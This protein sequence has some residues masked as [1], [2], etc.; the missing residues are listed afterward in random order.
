MLTDFDFARSLSLA[1]ACLAALEERPFDPLDRAEASAIGARVDQMAFV[2]FEIDAAAAKGAKTRLEEAALILETGGRWEEALSGWHNLAMW[3]RDPAAV[4]AAALDD[5]V[6]RATRGGWIGRAGQALVAKASLTLAG[7]AA[8]GDI[9]PLLARARQAFEAAGDTES[10]IDVERVRIML[11]LR[12]GTAGPAD[13]ERLAGDYEAADRPR[14]TITVLL[15]LSTLAHQSGDLAAATRLRGRIIRLAEATGLRLAELNGELA[16]VD[17]LLRGR[18]LSDAIDI[19]L[20]GMARPAP[21]FIQVQFRQMLAT[22]YAFAGDE[23]K[24]LDARRGALAE[25]T[26]MHAWELAS[27][28]ATLLANQR[29]GERTQAAWT[30]SRG[31]AR[32]WLDDD[33]TRGNI[34]GAL[35]NLRVAV[36][37]CWQEW[38]FTT[39]RPRPVERLAEADALLDRGDALAGALA[40]QARARELGGLAQQRGQTLQARG[41]PGEP[42]GGI[43]T[44]IQHYEAGGLAM[45]AANSRYL[46]GVIAL[47]A[48]AD[49]W[50]AGDRAA[51]LAS[52]GQAERRLNEALEYYDGAAMR[53]EAADTRF[54]L[55][56]HYANTAP[57]TSPPLPDQMRDGALTHLERAFADLDSARRQYASGKLSDAQVGKLTFAE[58]SS[59]IVALALEILLPQ[60]P[61]WRQAWDWT[62]RGKSRALSDL[63]GLY[64][65]PPRRIVEALQADPADA[66][67]LARQRDL[68]ARLAVAPPEAR[69]GLRAALDEAA[70]EVAALPRWRAYRQFTGGAPLAFDELAAVLSADEAGAPAGVCIDWVAVGERLYLIAARPGE[71]PRVAPI[72]LSLAHVGAFVRDHLDEAHFRQTLRDFPEV[73]EDMTPLVEPLAGLTRPEELLVLCPTGPLHAVPLHALAVDGAALIA[74]NP[75][76]YTH[77]LGVTG[78]AV[79]RRGDHQATRPMAVFG[80]PSQDRAA[81]AGVAEQLHERFAAPLFIGGQVTCEALF[82]ALETA[83]RVHFQGHAAYE[84]GSPLESGLEVVGAA[85]PDRVRV[86]DIL[87]SVR[88]VA[89]LVSL[90]ACES[91]ANAVRAGDD[92]LGVAPALLVAGAGGVLGALWRVDET[93]CAAFTERLYAGLLDPAKPLAT[94]DAL[95]SAVRA[96]MADPDTDTP[97]HWGAYVL[98]GDWR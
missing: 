1:K 91:A 68:V 18:R 33:V 13:L 10:Q 50:R 48:T 62:Q 80:D 5:V 54:M 72:A 30:E 46:L 52:F 90:G 71:P 96:L 19:C 79:S 77:S 92:P 37:A 94:T 6:E 24:C 14:D 16:L 61:R 81:A 56:R 95:R 29:L 57:M 93:A 2:Y 70:A 87:G 15:D 75:V 17:I 21:R 44:A 53:Q 36:D 49:A 47:N 65:R 66:D 63:L 89:E 9:E 35:A 25:L 55:A 78:H 42:E 20:A 40:G 51:A 8:V 38:V 26:E 32:R 83:R 84:A 12:G 31:L 28:A 74:R 76:V 97:Y 22:A 39:S 85:G 98:Y 43:R 64:A 59:R 73:L 88:V 69:P 86:S 41:V 7:G 11:A 60:P 4:Q 67:R 82:Q 3:P 23:P 45:E 58:K 27:P 34:E